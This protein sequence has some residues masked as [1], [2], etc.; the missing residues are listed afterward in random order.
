MCSQRLKIINFESGVM[1][2]SCVMIIFWIFLFSSFAF[3]EIRGFWVWQPE[4]DGVRFLLPNVKGMNPE[5]LAQRL[6]KSIKASFRYGKMENAQNLK[7][8]TDPS[9]FSG[10]PRSSSEHPNV[11][12]VL[13]RPKQMLSNNPYISTVIQSFECEGVRLFNIPVGLEM[14]LSNEDMEDFRNQLNRMD[15]QLGVGGDD[16]HPLIYGKADTSKTR[17]DIC[18]VRDLQQIAY[19]NAYRKNGLGRVFYICGSMQKAGIGDGFGFHP[20]IAHLTERPHQGNGVPILL[21]IEVEPDSELAQAA[22]STRFQT[23]NYHHGAINAHEIPDPKNPPTSRITAYN[24]EP[25]GKKGV[26][27]KAIEFP[28]HQGIATQFHPEFRGTDEE[29]RI[30]EYIAMG[31]KLPARPSSS[32]IMQCLSRSLS[33]PFFFK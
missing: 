21:E 28:D 25:S 8:S 32:K 18:E 24:I 7:L 26:I 13:N 33:K 15:G 27:V 19:F 22:G 14:V 20:D 30:I 31:W 12:V 4:P 2:F 6:Q 29:K 11:A 5:I 17:G 23:S 10:L 9:T 1:F 16:P 3:A